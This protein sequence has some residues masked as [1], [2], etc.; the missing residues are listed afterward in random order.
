MRR[1]ASRHSAVKVFQVPRSPRDR[2]AIDLM[3]HDHTV[4]RRGRVPGEA[5]QETV[6]LEDLPNRLD[7]LAGH[8]LHR[9]RHGRAVEDAHEVHSGLEG[10]DATGIALDARGDIPDVRNLIE[11]ILLGLDGSPVTSLSGLPLRT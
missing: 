3:G 1:Q 11:A 8:G 4:E 2:V 9:A 5:L 6:V 10:T 7:V